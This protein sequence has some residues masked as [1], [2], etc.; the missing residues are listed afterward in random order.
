VGTTTTTRPTVSS[1]PRKG[2]AGRPSIASR[3]GRVLLFRQAEMNIA[4]LGG[5]ATV[6]LLADAVNSPC[7]FLDVLKHSPLLLSR[8]EANRAWQHGRKFVKNMV[9]LAKHGEHRHLLRLTPKLH[10]L[11]HI[12][13]TLRI[14]RQF[15]SLK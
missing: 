7:S 6:N 10:Y 9:T 5:N 12:V 3:L 1:A 2:S 8:I 11:D 4:R 13:Q 14:H 15:A